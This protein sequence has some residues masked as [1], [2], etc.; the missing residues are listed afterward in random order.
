MPRSG[1]CAVCGRHINPYDSHWYDK[2]VDALYCTEPD[3]DNPAPI[4]PCFA[5]GRKKFL[6]RHNKEVFRLM[7]ELG[8]TYF[9]DG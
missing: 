4:G 7:Q 5:E 2:E 3:V 9:T 6:D 8:F 1:N